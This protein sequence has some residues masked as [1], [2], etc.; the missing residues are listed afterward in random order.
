MSKYQYVE[1]SVAFS[2][3][4]KTDMYNGQ[5]TGKYK[6]DVTIDPEFVGQLEEAGVKLKEYEGNS[7]R[8]FPSKFPVELVDVDGNP[9]PTIELPRGTKVRVLYSSGNSHP[10]FG[11]PTYLAKVKVLEM[12]E[13]EVEAPSDF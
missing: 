8:K 1:G 11:A 7:Q 9:I 13:A 6:L 3:L 4:T 5:D 12:G 10:Q 2:C